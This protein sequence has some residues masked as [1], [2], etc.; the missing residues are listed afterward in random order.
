MIIYKTENIV[1]NKVYIG[2]NLTDGGDGH[3]A[4]H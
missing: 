1:N 4:P 3:S 2:Y